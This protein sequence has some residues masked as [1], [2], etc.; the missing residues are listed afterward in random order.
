MNGLPM[1]PLSPEKRRY[2]RYNTKPLVYAALGSHY[3]RVGKVKDISIGGLAFE[4]VAGNDL[5]NDLTRID[6]FAAGNGIYIPAIAC[7]KIYE[8][9]IDNGLEQY[10]PTNDIAM[11]R[12]GVEFINPGRVQLTQLKE[13][14]DTYGQRTRF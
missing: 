7:R 3:S 14:I 1:S 4:Y 12:C 5:P 10:E 11:M 8:F 6:V 2:V 13:L 9:V